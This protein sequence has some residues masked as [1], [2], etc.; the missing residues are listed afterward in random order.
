[1]LLHVCFYWYPRGSRNYAY[2]RRTLFDLVTLPC[3]WS[4]WDYVLSDFW[5]FLLNWCGYCGR[6]TAT[7]R[8]TRRSSTRARF[9]R[10]Q[11]RRPYRTPML[12]EHRSNLR[13]SL[14]HKVVWQCHKVIFT[15]YAA[16]HPACYVR[17]QFPD[18][19]VPTSV[20]TK[21]NFWLQ[22]FSSSE[23]KSY[24]SLFSL[25][26]ISSHLTCP[27]GVHLVPRS[28]HTEYSQQD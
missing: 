3:D 8:L 9:Y 16:R 20:N 5:F 25:S 10:R 27:Q 11:L 17:V 23:V 21:Y 4:V 28:A 6:E 7:R 19:F 15:V 1:M 13:N 18:I 2:T 26:N 14:L 24:G 12:C 22:L